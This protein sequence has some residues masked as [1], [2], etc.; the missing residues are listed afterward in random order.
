MYS[1]YFLCN[2][3][4]KLLTN[5]TIDSIIRV[6]KGDEKMENKIKE[7]I[8]IIKLLEKLVISLISLIGWILILIEIIN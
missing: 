3:I 2:F 5:Y 1:P 8:K 4:E 6:W 7:L